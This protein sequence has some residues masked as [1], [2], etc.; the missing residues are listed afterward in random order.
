[1]CELQDDSDQA[2]SG[3]VNQVQVVPAEQLCWLRAIRSPSLAMPWG[4]SDWDRVIRL[5]HRHRLLARLAASLE[6]AGL[7]TAVPAQARNHLTAARHLSA[8]RTRAML[9]AIEWLPR[10]LNDPEYPLVLLKG[11]A[12]LGQE[13]A[14]ADGRLPSDLDILVPYARLLEIR[15]L[16]RAGGW[17]EP[18]LDEHD[19]R[20]YIE[21]SHELPPLTHPAHAIELDVHH[22]ILPPRGGKSLDAKLL[23]ENL[24]PSRW[25]HWQ[26][27]SPVDQ[28]LHSAAHLFYDSEPRDRVRDLVDMDGLMRHFGADPKFWHELPQRASALGLMEPLTLACHFTHSWLDTPIP[29]RLSLTLKGEGPGAVRLRWL[30][31]LMER[32]LLPTEPDDEDSIAKKAA[33]TIV[34]ARYHSHRMPL[35]LLVPHLWHKMRARNSVDSEAE[36]GT[37]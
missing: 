10:T 2:S 29:E 37:A 36:P 15:F 18:R 1:M 13:L 33:L 5:A 27:L 26:V 6:R 31:P 3:P 23:F 12:Y 25:P 28:L 19:R 17:C 35:R 16:L 22:N 4:L 24:G 32:V 7:M 14:I 30:L 34:L 21:W 20:F 9:W 11:A 8:A